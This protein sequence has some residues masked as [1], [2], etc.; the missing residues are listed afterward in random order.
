M[1]EIS[2]A[3]GTKRVNL[4]VI[5]GNEK[6][7]SLFNKLGFKETMEFLVLRRA[8]GHSEA[9]IDGQVTL[10]GK[11]AAL[12][13]LRAVPR[14]TWINDIRSMSNAADIMGVSLTMG[15]GSRGWILFRK[16]APTLS[17]IILHTEIGAPEVVGANLT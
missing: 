16:K 4:E 2:K 15:D 11:D 13:L 7:W 12:D 5:N 8:P 3:R 10:L 6:A 9:N 14:Q 1:L 17:H